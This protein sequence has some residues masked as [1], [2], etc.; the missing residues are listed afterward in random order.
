LI[1]NHVVSTNV[2]DLSTKA[3]LNYW[4]ES[5]FVDP[6]FNALEMTHQEFLVTISIPDY[7]AELEK[8]VK[9]K[10]KGILAGEEFPPTRPKPWS[11]RRIWETVEGKTMLNP[12]LYTKRTLPQIRVW[13]SVLLM[14]IFLLSACSSPSPA[15]ATLTPPP[16]TPV[17]ATPEA[18]TRVVDVERL[19]NTL[20][21]LVAY[22][23]PD[24]PTV[25]E[26]GVR[27][28]A[29]FDPEGL[30]SGSA[31]CNYYTGTF[32]AS[33]DGSLSF[34]PQ[35]TTSMECSRGMELEAAYLATLQNPESFDFSEQGRLQINTLGPS[36]ERLQLVYTSGQAA[37]TGNTWVLVSY[38]DPAAPETVPAGS[39][40]TV[41]FSD[42]GWMSGFSGC[43]SFNTS[44]IAEDG[45]LSLGTLASSMMECSIDMERERAFQE[46]ISGVQTYEISGPDLTLMHNEGADALNFTSAHLPLEHTLWTLVAID[47]QAL[48]DDINITALF[49]PGEEAGQGAVGGSSGCNNYSAGYTLDGAE[50]SVEPPLTTMMACPDIMDIEY[51][52]LQGL[53][54]AQSF[55]I[56]ADRLVLRTEYGT[57][58][59]AANRTPLAGA[60]WTLIGIGDIND[61]QPPIQGS[62]FTAQ[63][64][65]IPDAPS[66]LLVG[67]TGCNEYASAYAASID[68]IRINAPS[69]T[70]SQSCVP[71]LVDQEELYFLALAD[72]A[73]YRISGNSLIIPYDEGRQALI[74]VGTQIEVGQRL[75]LSDLDRTTWY[76]WFL[77]NQPVAA[78]TTISARFTLNPDSV[79]GKLDGEAGCNRYTATFG[80]QLGMQTSLNGRQT[81][82]KPAG[83]MEQ[84]RGY[85]G[86]LERAYGYWLTANQLVLNSGQGILIYR[87]TQPPESFD[88]THLLVGPNWY[89]VSHNNSYSVPGDREP[90]I[91]FTEEGTMNGFTGC[92]NIGADFETEITRISF[93]DIT[94]T[95][96]TCPDRVLDAQETAILDI[97]GSARSYQL[98]DT[99]M[100][101]VGDRG[102]LNFS[103]TPVNRPDEIQPPQAV[104][105]APAQARVGE[106]VTFD[107][108]SSSAQL[109]ITSWR[110]DFGDGTEV[111]ER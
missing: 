61:P 34:G 52:Y 103:L 55:E 92:N 76:L 39:V 6:K 40:L 69:R 8:L 41:N 21:V 102:V 47:G 100:Q 38:G 79:S 56:F 53:E 29:E 107:G 90:F 20:W 81:C 99:V 88:Q 32:D 59:F 12:N 54:S 15:P 66:G 16:A 10:E 50:I 23:D 95:E 110:W 93:G 17:P 22:G 96:Q 83:V 48:A 7:L 35:V 105:N 62:S 89:L 65:S 19:F 5:I 108:S 91:R 42:D 18:E 80:E 2:E 1:Q 85:L 72:A 25:I 33:S 51:L 27:I 64:M 109:P 106:V 111:Q 68:E 58:T 43:N 28:T 98:V 44:F 30:V 60:L 97:L 70:E 74:Y 11:Y 14:G 3:E 67:T 73:N 86:V 94:A 71:G 13:L 46:A 87:Q 78:G 37:L 26:Q 9:L 84:E 104:I 31:G 36:G 82:L 24:N 4:M 77:N 49:E 63:F 75:P 101:I 57:F 45:K